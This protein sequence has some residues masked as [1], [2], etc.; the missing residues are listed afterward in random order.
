M[1]TSSVEALRYSRMPAL[2]SA[3]MGMPQPKTAKAPTAEAAGPS[4]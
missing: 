4:R 3:E 1:K 2:R